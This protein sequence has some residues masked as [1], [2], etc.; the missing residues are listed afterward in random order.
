MPVRGTLGLRGALTLGGRHQGVR[1]GTPPP[2]PAASAEP[3]P[4]G[5]GGLARPVQWGVQPQ[6]CSPSPLGSQPPMLLSGLSP[7]PGTEDGRE[8]RGQERPHKGHTI[9]FWDTVPPGLCLPARRL[10]C[11]FPCWGLP[12]LPSRP[13]GHQVSLLHPQTGHLSTWW[14]HNGAVGI[15]QHWDCPARGQGCATPTPNPGPGAG[16]G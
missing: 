3:L 10:G 9:L 8:I 12:D 1:C 14:P 11:G 13:R 6:A 15:G 5:R 2:P 7:E 4:G 16:R